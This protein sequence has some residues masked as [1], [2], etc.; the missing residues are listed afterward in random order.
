MSKIKLAIFLAMFAL[1]ARSAEYE[2][3][4]YLMDTAFSVVITNK[5]CKIESM[6]DKMQLFV[7]GKRT[8]DQK[9]VTYVGGCYTERNGFIVLWWE[10]SS[11]ILSIPSRNFQ[12]YLTI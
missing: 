11:T 6:K 5:P 12:P 3:K 10:N 9:Q 4:L 2:E 1:I 7:Y 8:D